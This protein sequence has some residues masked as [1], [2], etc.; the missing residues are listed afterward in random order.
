[1]SQMRDFASIIYEKNRLRILCIV[2]YGPGHGYVVTG[3]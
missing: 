3:V 2:D 1:M